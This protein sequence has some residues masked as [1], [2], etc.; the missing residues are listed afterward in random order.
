M[1]EGNLVASGRRL[2]EKERK[3]NHIASERQR[4]EAVRDGFN[5]LAALTPGM[6]GQGRSE[7]KVLLATL[8]YHKEQL[9]TKNQ[10]RSLWS[11][12]G[13]SNDQFESEYKNEFA[14]LEA[15]QDDESNTT[16]NHSINNDN[17]NNSSSESNSAIDPAINNSQ[18][19]LNKSASPNG[20][21][22]PRL[23]NGTMNSI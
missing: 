23:N 4:R 15:E 7:V 6:A 16:Q 13:L 22:T 20:V 3:D 2:T 10:L 21:G 14:R 9:S 18:G 1:A 5:A 8:Q 19:S 12:L 17:T 11:S